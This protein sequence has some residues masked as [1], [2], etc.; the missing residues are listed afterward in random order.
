MGAGQAGHLLVLATS[1]APWDLDEA[2]RRRLEKRIY[3]PLPDEIARLKMF[4]E[5]M[6][7]IQLATGV[8]FAT[9]AA[10]TE[11]YSGADIQLICRDASMNP[12]RRMVDGLTPMELVR[13]RDEGLLA[14]D[15]V[16]V[17]MADFEAALA[18][19]QPSVAPGDTRRYAEWA[20]DFGSK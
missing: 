12:M 2:L 19:V 1:N 7:D 17:E 18:S 20:Q 16:P 11:H 14:P 15:G 9:L 13:L 6:S 4:S 3:I 10:R 8:D 5:N